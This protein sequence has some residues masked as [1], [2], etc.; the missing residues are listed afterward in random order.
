MR[1]KPLIIDISEWQRPAVINY[2]LLAKQVGG[3][4]I[5]IQYGSAYVDKH[6]QTHIKEF[7]KRGIP[8]AVYAWVRGINF[9]DMARE[10]EFF[11]LRGKEFQP[12][13]WWLDVEE[14]SM[15]EM[16]SGCEIYR[17]TL[18]KLGAKKVGVYIA[19]HLYKQLN[20]D[21]TAFDGIWLPTYGA[22]SGVY[23]GS[24]PTATTDY[25]LHQYTSAGRLSGYEGPLDLNRLHRKTLSYFF[26]TSTEGE[27][28]FPMKTFNL[29]TA[30]YLRQKPDRKSPTIALLSVGQKIKINDIC[31]ADGFLWGVQP[32]EDGTKGFFAL[33][34]FS[35]YGQFN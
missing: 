28:D 19:N 25:D 16:R 23:T 9:N 35:G 17:R 3:V 33:G 18:K 13:F 2:D 31:I 24:N 22:N 4:I 10:A 6:Y 5:R 29:T 11:W 21:V 30:V 32:R 12:S 1:P 15:K 34:K 26:G 14:L 20:L 8:F 27:G 7:K